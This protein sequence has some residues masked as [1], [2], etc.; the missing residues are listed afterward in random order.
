[1]ATLLFAL[2]FKSSNAD[3]VR[4]FTKCAFLLNRDP[5]PDAGGTRL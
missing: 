3:A 4:A 5:Q 2:P 1:M